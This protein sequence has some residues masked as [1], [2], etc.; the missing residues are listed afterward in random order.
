MVGTPLVFARTPEDL[1]AALATP[2]TWSSSI[3][4][5]GI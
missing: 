2:R 5:L 1:T 3:S 4:R